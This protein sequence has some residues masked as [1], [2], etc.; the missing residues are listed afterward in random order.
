M[1]LW[2]NKITKNLNFCFE[3]IHICNDDL[4]ILWNFRNTITMNYSLFCYDLLFLVKFYHIAL[5]THCTACSWSGKTTVFV[6]LCNEVSGRFLCG[7]WLRELPQS[8]P[9]ALQSFGRVH[10]AGETL[11]KGAYS[12]GVWSQRIFAGACTFVCLFF[13]NNRFFF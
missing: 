5:M 9:A 11:T 4:K 12:D 3:E 8:L 2:Q 13:T 1:Q 7:P 10:V 6:E